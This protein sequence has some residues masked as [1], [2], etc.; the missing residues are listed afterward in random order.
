MTTTEPLRASSLTTAESSATFSTAI[1]TPHHAPTP[2]PSP[3]DYQ[4][5]PDEHPQDATPHSESSQSPLLSSFP[6]AT[7]PLPT[8]KGNLSPITPALDTVI[9]RTLEATER[10]RASGNEQLEVKVRLDS[11]H[12]V[13]VSLHLSRGEIKPT[14]LTDSA[15]LRHA[16]ENHWNQFSDQNPERSVRITTPIFASTQ[17]ESGQ[18]N[19]G[20]KHRDP[21]DQTPTHPTESHPYRSTPNT[22]NP[23]STSPTIPQPTT[24]TD[25]IHLYA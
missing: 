13:T 25:R 21:R 16:L 24:Q 14:F 7:S 5:S 11:G 4:Q 2:H 15:E 12:E 22:R 18:N 23:R 6:D 10:L 20:Q 3:E 1:V 19:L 8:P 9:Q 17:T